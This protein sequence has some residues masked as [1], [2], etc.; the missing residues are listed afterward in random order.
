MSLFSKLFGKS[1]NDI[2]A[3]PR[4]QEPADGVDWATQAV[5][6]FVPSTSSIDSAI[7]G[8]MVTLLCEMT[9]KQNTLVLAP[10][11]MTLLAVAAL[12]VI[13]S[14]TAGTESDRPSLHIILQ[15]QGYRS[16]K[17]SRAQRLASL[18]G[19]RLVHGF[20]AKDPARCVASVRQVLQDNNLLCWK[21]SWASS[22]P[23]NCAVAGEEL[24]PWKPAHV[25]VMLTNPRDYRFWGASVAQ[26]DSKLA[27]LVLCHA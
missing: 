22:F 10:E 3:P 4:F 1:Q 11:E 14:A 19:L 25:V 18:L 27:Y 13:S 8:H 16:A 23:R 17:S 12:G 9:P 6:S 26:A 15:D 21:T 20:A 24:L 2:E 5:S 7:M